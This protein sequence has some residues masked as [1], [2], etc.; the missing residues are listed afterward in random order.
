MKRIPNFPRFKEKIYIICEGIGD[1]IYLDRIFSFYDSNYNI[2]VISSSGKN[3]IVDK[4]REV[5]ILYPHNHC[6]LFVDGDKNA[7]QTIENYKRLMK[8]NEIECTNNIY[9]V[10]PIIEY[11]YLIT[12]VDRHPT[13][14]YTK[15]QYRKLFEKYFGITEYTGAQKQYEQMASKIDVNAF[16]KNSNKIKKNINETPSSTIIDLINKVIKKN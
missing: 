4:L 14:Y 16:E 7:R 13:N 15:E 6:F 12:Q 8:Q 5:L 1:K 3:R 10:N 11:L 2:N 9:F